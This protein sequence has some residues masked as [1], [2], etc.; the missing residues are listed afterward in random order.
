MNYHREAT[1]AIRKVI[2]SGKMSEMVNA[3]AAKHPK[4]FVMSVTEKTGGLTNHSNTAWNKAAL[5]V[6][7]TGVNHVAMVHQ[8]A[9]KHPKSF[10][11]SYDPN[12][13]IPKGI[14]KVTL[15]VDHYGKSDTFKM[16]ME[17]FTELKAIC[18]HE[19]EMKRNIAAIKEVRGKT[20]WDLLRSKRFFDAIVQGD[21]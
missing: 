1:L 6:L 16:P 14:K 19:H 15:P 4:S 11:Q 8:F 20:N 10:L 2:D 13:L 12:M 18:R 7:Q 17:L 3:F 5:R 9:I 21:I